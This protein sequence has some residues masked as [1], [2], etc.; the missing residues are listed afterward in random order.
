[1]S[2]CWADCAST[3]SR[4][5]CCSWRIW[6]DQ[7]L[8]AL[9][10]ARH[11]RRALALILRIDGDGLACRFLHDGRRLGLDMAGQ[12]ILKLSVET[13]LRLPRLQIQKTENQRTG[14]AEQRGG[15][16]QAHSRDGSR[17]AVLEVVEHRRRVGA[18]LHAV[19]DATDRM[20]GLQ[21]APEGAE[22]AQKHQKTD[23]IAIEFAALVEPR[24]DRVENCARRRGGK[25]ARSGAGVEHR[26]HRRKQNG[27]ADPRVRVRT[28]E[29]IDPSYLA[30]QSEHLTVG[31]RRADQ[32]HQNDEPVQPGIGA[33]G[34]LDRL[35]QDQDDEPDQDQKGRH[36]DQ[37]NPGRGEKANIGFRGHRSGAG[38]WRMRCRHILAEMRRSVKREAT[39]GRGRA[40]FHNRSFSQGAASAP[41]VN[42]RVRAA[43]A[44]LRR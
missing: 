5:C 32:K 2:S 31:E 1:M 44:V 34:D 24:A 16:P 7:G 37:K 13:I 22:Q 3:Q 35:V 21:Q 40:F 17:E 38:T 25:T 9:G 8:D 23:E 18:R 36:P 42:A 33:E 43:A 14:E 11:R 27:R 28:D 4:I 10:Q 20:H 29:R 6:V 15:E 19:D 30:E 41:G 39:N 12:K 26:R